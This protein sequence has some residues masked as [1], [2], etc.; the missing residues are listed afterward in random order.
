[1]SSKKSRAKLRAIAKTV[2]LG[3]R[4]VKVYWVK[5]YDS[6]ALWCFN[7]HP[8]AQDVLTALNSQGVKL[9]AVML[10]RIVERKFNVVESVIYVRGPSLQN[11]T[12]AKEE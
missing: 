6:P 3:I 1:M 8:D 7:F 2:T 12:D 10:G 9:D 11:G 5:P 4:A